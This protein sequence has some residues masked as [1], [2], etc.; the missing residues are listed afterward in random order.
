MHLSTTGMVLLRILTSSVGWM[1]GG[2]AEDQVLKDRVHAVNQEYIPVNGV[3]HG[4]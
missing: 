4:S 1:H 2:L 3:G